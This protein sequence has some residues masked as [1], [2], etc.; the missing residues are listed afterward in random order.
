[1]KD[2]IQPTMNMTCFK[3]VNETTGLISVFIQWEVQNTSLV[4]EAIQDYQIW[5]MLMDTRG[6]IPRAL[7]VAS[8]PK[9]LANVS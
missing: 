1:M 5:T 2:G 8:G 6:K 7:D 3:Y 4:L 9:I